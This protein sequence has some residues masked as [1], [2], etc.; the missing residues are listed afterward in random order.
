[1][2]ALGVACL[3]LPLLWP[4]VF[5]PLTWGSLVFLLEPW[6]RRHARRSFLRDLE[7]GEAGPLRAARCWPG[8]SA[9]R[10]GRPGTSGRARSGCTPCPASRD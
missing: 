1:M 4:D 2:I 3:V 10:C 7:A 8:S 6:N 9:A 5:F